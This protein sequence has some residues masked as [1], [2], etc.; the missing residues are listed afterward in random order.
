MSGYDSMCEL[1][2]THSSRATLRFAGETE[3]FRVWHLGLSNEG[4]ANKL[5]CPY[6][7]GVPQKTGA[8]DTTVEPGG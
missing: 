4:A 5:T 7:P 3:S 2:V 8:W 1:S 6:L